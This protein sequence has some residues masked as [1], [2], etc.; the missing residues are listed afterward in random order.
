MSH[1]FQPRGRYCAFCINRDPR[2]PTAYTH[3]LKDKNGITTC[4]FLLFTRCGACGKCGHTPVYCPTRNK[5]QKR[6]VDVSVDEL[7]AAVGGMSTKP[8]EEMDKFEEVEYFMAKFKQESH[9][10]L[11]QLEE[12]TDAHERDQPNKCCN[13]CRNYNPHDPFCMTHNTYRVLDRK[14]VCPRLQATQCPHCKKLGHTKFHCWEWNMQQ[15]VKEAEARG[16]T[17]FIIDFSKP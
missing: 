12:Y 14:L 10:R 9:E 7:T 4:P 15:S 6:H 3:Y 8:L 2:D 16:E 1:H 5:N 11:R 13:Y 17:E